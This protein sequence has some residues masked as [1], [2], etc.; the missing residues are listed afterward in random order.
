[1]RMSKE[2][3]EALL[4]ALARGESRREIARGH[5]VSLT[6]VSYWASRSATTGGAGSSGR[7][8]PGRPPVLDEAGL[9]VFRA[10]LLERRQAPLSEILP[11]LERRI[12]VRLN[13]GTARHYLTRMGI[14][15]TEPPRREAGADPLPAADPPRYGPQHRRE[16]ADGI[17]PTD[18]LDEEWGLL[19]PLFADKS[20]PGRPPQIPRRRI[21]DAIF[22]VV[23]TGVQWRNLPSDLPKW[24]NVYAHFRR[25]STAG[26]FESM[27]DLLRARWREREGRA[28]AATAGVVDSQSVKT[29]EKGGPKGT[30]A[31]RRSGGGSA[32][33]S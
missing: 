12:G 22:Y 21:L 2:T 6:T 5:G 31:V 18:L 26:R 13:E 8:K 24:Q 9:A 11:E 20:R 27:H 10:L 25:W 3:R 29:T 32:T 23:R 30:T 33:S 15:R 4:A 17:Y 7:R 16:A 19:E 28:A 1:M 14:R